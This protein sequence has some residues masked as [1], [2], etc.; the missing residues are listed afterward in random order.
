MKAIML[1]L[2][3]GSSLLTMAQTASAQSAN[4]EPTGASTGDSLND[5]IIVTA[6]RRDE[7]VQD[8]PFVVDTVTANEISKL[9]M[10]DFK[11]IQQ[12]V[13]GLDLSSRA[14]GIGA[15]ASIRG[16]NFDIGVSGNNPTVE[17]YLNDAPITAGIVLQQMFD[18]GQIEVLRG[19]QGT[20]RGR[21]SPS[22]SITVTSRK[23]DLFGIGG[24]LSGTG[25]GN[26]EIN[27]NGAINV[28]IVEG[29][30]AIRAAGLIDESDFNEVR[31]INKTVDGRDP[32]Q[33]TA[34]GRVSLV[35]QPTDWLHLEGMYQR[36]DRKFRSFEQVE[37]FN[38]VDPNAPASPT[39]IRAKDR[40]GIVE[41]PD[42]ISQKYDIFTWNA[43][44]SFAGQNLIYV[45]S[46]RKQKIHSTNNQ[47][48]AN[49]FQN[50][51]VFQETLTK[52]IDKSHEIRLQNEERIGGLFDYVVGVFR[53][54]NNPPSSVLSPTVL[55][56]PPALGGTVASV[57]QTPIERSGPSKENSA[58]A[59]V[60]LHIGDATEVSGGL[61]YIDIES[62][63]KLIVAGSTVIDSP[64]KD[65]KLIYS[66]SVKH[67]ITPD[68]MVYAN[69]G[70][71]FRAGPTAI[72]DF[73]VVKSPLQQQFTTLPPESSTSYEAGIKSEFMNGRLLFNLSGYY[74]KFKNYPY[75]APN[76]G[77][78]YIN[79]SASRD[80]TGA[81]NVTP[82]VDD[83][84]FVAAVP[85]EVW[86]IEAQTSFKITPDWD[87]SASVSYA[88]GKIKNGLIPCDDLNGDGRPDSITT[89]P[90][91]AQLQTAYGSN[92]L[93][94]CRVTQ[95]SSFQSPFSASVQSEY[96]VAVSDKT[97]AYLRGLFSFY[98]KSQNDPSNAFDDVAAYGL[99]NLF[100]G[101]RDPGGMWEVSFYAKNVFD[102]LKVLTRTRPLITNY[103][104]LVLGPSGPIG[105]NA[106]TYTSTYTGITTTAPREFGLSVRFS[107]GSR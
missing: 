57:R 49:F 63:S 85:V 8:V 24:T 70:T 102:T 18:V 46:Y 41:A 29:I 66:A 90:S 1:P 38:L 68:V 83:F 47:D 17:F 27:F 44:L 61:R 36:T 99:L 86:G 53:Q 10:R 95:R 106:M 55:V 20:L 11:E 48:D 77:V 25:T 23:P 54:D 103:R 94:G 6:R 14:D 75:R 12:L 5:A 13:P 76:N 72:G 92:N 37:S 73:S 9:N 26:G 21:A 93:A 59:N 7:N 28:P 34:S 35:V 88:N 31:T 30:A 3:I 22:G 2:M 87:I 100:T 42:L 107:F 81:V 4:Q 43:K 58:F 105:A 65:H 82:I 97:E 98:G 39:L 40:R 96:R 15:S 64:A 89:T 19:P 52:S 32:Y 84:N 62:Q 91:L 79:Y 104:E 50:F 69:T 78:Y 74:Q 51:D 71:S 33:R 56:L 60:T 80:A 101:V 67:R 16:I 45:G